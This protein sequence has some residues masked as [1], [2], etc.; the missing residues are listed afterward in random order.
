M[1]SAE[2]AMGDNSTLQLVEQLVQELG[3]ADVRYCHWKSNEH[4]DESLV[5][6]GDLDILIA[7]EDSLRAEAV[8]AKL[9]FKHFL[10]V[11]TKRY[12][13]ITDF[14]GFDNK[15]GRL[16]H[17][18]THYCL[19][20]G[21][22]RLKDYRLPWEDELLRTIAPA[23]GHTPIP[24]PSPEAE[25]LMLLVRNCLKI[26]IRDRLLPGL[27]ARALMN[28]FEPDRV[29]LHEQIDMR[30]LESLS[31]KWLGPRLWPQV[32]AIAESPCDRKA[33]LRLRKGIVRLLSIFRNY[34][35]FGSFLRG[36]QREIAW[37]IGV[38]NKRYLHWARPWGR[39]STTGGTIVCILGAD[40]AGK[41]TLTKAIVRWLIFKLDAIPIYMGGG[42]GFSSIL[43]KPLIFLRKFLVKT[44]RRNSVDGER[45]PEGSAPEKPSIS[46]AAKVGLLPWGVVLAIEKRGKL[47]KVSRAS[48]RGMI[49]VA[50]RYPQAQTHGFNDGPL[51]Q[52]FRESRWGW[53][54]AISRWELGIYGTADRVC[55]DLVVKLDVP[56]ETALAR[57]SDMGRDEINRRIK[58]V[59]AMSFPERT[60][61]V[62][63]P[64]DLP[65]DE[66]LARVK[67]AIWSVV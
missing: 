7:R 6:E 46:F 62:V 50:D 42:K 47:K 11:P 2:F 18:H 49:V 39:T 38:I 4:L 35:P 8:F 26:R 53:L 61:V 29:W 60:K 21:M 40:G 34:S 65:L 45:R 20:L 32:K 59:A 5:G 66:V 51:L 64:A 28:D 52:I 37:M 15:S 10:A 63:V 54:R 57:K 55:P 12:N 13:G 3:A 58:A 24:L 44:S 43:R 33:L 9:G 22:H 17:L 67:K 19:T 16:V 23:S 56:I 25:M 36:R 14:V 27:H 31:S 48:N 30:K 41:S 1:R